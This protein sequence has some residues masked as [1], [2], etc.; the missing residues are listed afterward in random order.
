MTHWRGDDPCACVDQ[1]LVD[2]FFRDHARIERH[3]EQLPALRCALQPKINR[4]LSV[5]QISGDTRQRLDV[6]SALLRHFTPHGLQAC[7]RS[8]CGRHLR[9]H[10]ARGAAVRRRQLTTQHGQR[11][12][13]GDAEGEAW[14]WH[15]RAKASSTA[16]ASA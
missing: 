16:R 6:S 14:P 7:R 3:R 2:L 15:Q 1:E 9:R 10:M 4:Q 8:S 5:L 13:A 12:R 11:E